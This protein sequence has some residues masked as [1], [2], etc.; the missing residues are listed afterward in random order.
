MDRLALAPHLN[1]GALQGDVVF[2]AY[3][4]GFRDG[5]RAD[6]S[7][8][9]EDDEAALSAVGALGGERLEEDQGLDV[10]EA[11]QALLGCAAAVARSC[12]VGNWLEGPE[13][14]TA[15]IVRCTLVLRVSG[16]LLSR[17]PA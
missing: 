9:S 7:R 13:G 12:V 17:S 10:R 3:V 1:L 2:A 14:S 8:R 15:P 16:M 6:D 4:Q 5:Q 11:L